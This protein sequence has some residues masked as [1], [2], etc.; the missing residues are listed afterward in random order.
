MRLEIG[1]SISLLSTMLLATNVPASLNRF[2]ISVT[3]ASVSF[4]V[5]TGLGNM[6]PSLSLI[7]HS[8]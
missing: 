2:V 1:R 3:W 5:S 7:L 6:E 8:F 4:F